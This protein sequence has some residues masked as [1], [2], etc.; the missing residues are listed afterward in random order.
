M[1]LKLAQPHLHTILG[2][3]L[4]HLPIG[5]IQGQLLGLLPR[6]IEDLHRLGPTGF[7]AVIDFA[8]IQQMSL[9]PTSMRSHLFRNTPIAMVFA[10]FK[11]VMALEKWFGHG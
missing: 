3:V 8:Q 4:R 2:G 1:Q 11:P 7:L 5:W 10:V 6:R 9:H